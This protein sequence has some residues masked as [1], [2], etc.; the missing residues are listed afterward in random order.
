VGTVNATTFQCASGTCFAS[1]GLSDGGTIGFDWIDAEIA[2]TLTI[3][4]GS[5][6]GD[7]IVDGSLDTSEIDESTLLHDSLSGAGTVD[8]IAEW[9]SSCTD[10]VGTSDIGDVLT[11][12]EITDI[13]LFNT[14]DTATGDYDFTGNLTI[15]EK[16]TFS[17]GELIDNIVNGWLR[18]TGNLNVTGDVSVT[19]NV[20]GNFIKGDGSELTGISSIPTDYLNFSTFAGSIGSSY[21]NMANGT[22]V[23]TTGANDVIWISWMVLGENDF[24]FT[25][26]TKLQR[27][28]V[29]VPGTEFIRGGA[30]QFTDDWASSSGSI[31]DVPGSG[32]H[33][34]KV[35]ARCAENICSDGSRVT[36]SAIQFT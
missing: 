33:T 12:S 6:A 5:I 20:T 35:Q 11:A 10:C 31:V 29:D 19:G 26:Y 15:G 32:T 4:G 23:I 17:F 30:N 2:D 18:I 34:Y 3:T 28:G 14:G 13:Y 16:I 25:L 36:I 22:L 8:T 7:I 1:T 21:M 24:R 9:Q 27:N